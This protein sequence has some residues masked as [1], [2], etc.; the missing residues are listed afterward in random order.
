MGM[1]TIAAASKKVPIL[2]FGLP[3]SKAITVK[4]LTFKRA[5]NISWDILR[6]N[7]ADLIILP[8]VWRTN[9]VLLDKGDIARFMYNTPYTNNDSVKYIIHITHRQFSPI[10]FLSGA[11][12]L[13]YNPIYFSCWRSNCRKIARR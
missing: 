7:R 4:R 3:F 13:A 2:T 12:Q 8:K 1:L 11:N 5:A 9:N 6:S 10:F